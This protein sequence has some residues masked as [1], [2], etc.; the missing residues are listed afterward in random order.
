MIWSTFIRRSTLIDLVCVASF[1]APFV[2]CTSALAEDDVRIAVISDMSNPG[3]AGPSI[4]LAV[5]LALEDARASGELTK[6]VSAI[7]MDDQCKPDLATNFGRQA[8]QNDRAVLVIGHS[9]TN[10]SVAASHLYQELN[11]LQ[12]DPV[13]THPTLTERNRGKKVPIFRVAE[14]QDRAAT[15]AVIAL[16]NII[17]GNNV[18]L[19]GGAYQ[20]PWFDRFQALAAGKASQIS[21]KEV[22]SDDAKGS[23]VSIIYDPY[24][25][26]RNM[27]SAQKGDSVYAVYGPDERFGV[28]WGNRE[29][30]EK[31]VGRLKQQH[32][33]PP[34]GA[35]INAYASVQ[36][37]AQAQKAAG[38]T[39]TDRV[40]DQMRT[41]K[42]DTIRG[43]ISFDETGDV[44]Q[45]IITI[46]RYSNPIIEVPNQCNEPACKDCK[47]SDCCH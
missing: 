19:V 18:S 32:L 8:V 15:I 2:V 30:V 41:T 13:T 3:A 35:A 14:R 12:I 47:C 7:V 9:C 44:R 37:W 22:L 11:I 27:D 20:K 28:S 38:S 1:L 24:Y 40:A 29:A 17:A 39:E 16:K 31:L 45:P 6:K 21:T 23:G 4:A 36:V 25:L 42:F 5:K 33:E 10:A 34:F 43:M 26:G 46:V